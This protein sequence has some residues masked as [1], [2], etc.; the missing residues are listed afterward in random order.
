MAL[1]RQ[2]R[3]VVPEPGEDWS[4][5]ARRALPSEPA[6]AAI[7]KLKSW[8]LQLFARIPPGEL[9]GSDVIFVEPPLEGRAGGGSP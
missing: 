9:L 6:A 8:N 3:F 2:R 4:A 5:L 1:S 7:E